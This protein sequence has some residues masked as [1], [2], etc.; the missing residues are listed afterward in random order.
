MNRSIKGVCVDAGMIIVADMDYFKQF[1][2]LQLDTSL[3][4]II[5]V[6]VGTYDVDW[7]MPKTYRG[8]VSGKGILKVT[9]G[10]VVVSDPCYLIKLQDEWVGW[11]D[12][13]YVGDEKK[14]HN[15]TLILD[16][17][18]GDG[19]WDVFLSLTAHAKVPALGI[20]AEKEGKN[21]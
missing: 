10:R 6:P 16:S 4:H 3:S 11:L 21:E 12:S 9:S 13:V 8:D 2:S 15:G 18:G 7:A 20:G 19:V 5:A 17:M 14:A 1:S